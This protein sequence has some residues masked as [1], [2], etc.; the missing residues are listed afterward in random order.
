MPLRFTARAIAALAALCFSA[1]HAQVPERTIDEIK[2]EAQARAERG[3]Y[4][5][6]GLDPADVRDAL[7]RIKTRDRDEWA[8]GFGAV[9]ARYMAQ[10]QAA[11]DPALAAAQ[12]QR[13]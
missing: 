6:G 12:Y 8:A 2:T 13:A 10:A 1:A 9:A 7:S 11:S 4:P 3:A 5:M